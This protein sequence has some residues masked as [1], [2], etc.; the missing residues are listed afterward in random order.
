MFIMVIRVPSMADEITLAT[1]SVKWNFCMERVSLKIGTS[2]VFFSVN[3]F[4]PWIRENGSNMRTREQCLLPRADLTLARRS[5][6]LA[7]G[8]LE[9]LH[10]TQAIR[11]NT[12]LSKHRDNLSISF[13]EYFSEQL[14]SKNC[15]CYVYQNELKNRTQKLLRFITCL[16]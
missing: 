3:R 4:F 9:R 6:S 14:S 2:I 11:M 1:T 16:R 15:N 8:L 13:Q 10:A 7:P 5:K 12:K